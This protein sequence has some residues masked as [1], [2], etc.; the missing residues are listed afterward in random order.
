MR[1]RI[2]NKNIKYYLKQTYSYNNIEEF[3]KSSK[4]FEKHREKVVGNIIKTFTGYKLQNGKLTCYNP[5]TSKNEALKIKN[6][7]HIQSGEEL[8]KELSLL[9]KTRMQMLT[10][11]RKRILKLSKT[12]TVKRDYDLTATIEKSKSTRL[13][14]VQQKQQIGDKEPEQ[15]V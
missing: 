8:L 10:Q 7:N 3:F 12:K 9:H 1:P 13:K 15:E 2:S 11:S 14:Q 6:F 5:Y 4:D